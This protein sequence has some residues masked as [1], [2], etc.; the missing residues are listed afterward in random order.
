MSTDASIHWPEP[1]VVQTRKG[2]I[3]VLPM[4]WQQMVRCKPLFAAMFALPASTE[5][6]VALPD[7]LDLDPIALL[8]TH[9]EETMKAMAILSN[10]SDEF[11]GSL[12]VDDAIKLADALITV[13]EGFFLQCVMPMITRAMRNLIR[14]IGASL[15]TMP[16][17]GAASSPS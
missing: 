7:S 1:V 12:L 3:K 16:A 15:P 14:V 13:N 8:M 9:P 2:E 5:G 6:R 11:V 4:E 17:D 10:Q